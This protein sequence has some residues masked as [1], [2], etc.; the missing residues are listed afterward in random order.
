MSYINKL[1]KEKADKTDC[2]II[3]LSKVLNQLSKA[4]FLEKLD[5]DERGRLIRV[6]DSLE[7]K[8][9]EASTLFIMLFLSLKAKTGSLE[10]NE[11]KS[12]IDEFF[13]DL[14]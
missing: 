5:E 6:L 12:F 8:M 7:S 9:D 4:D 11:M 2:S 3:A 14:R 13:K 10:D 1:I